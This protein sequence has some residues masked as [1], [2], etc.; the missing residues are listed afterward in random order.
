ME[1]RRNHEFETHGRITCKG[2]CVLEKRVLFSLHNSGEKTLAFTDRLFFFPRGRTLKNVSLKKKIERCDAGWDYRASFFSF[3]ERHAGLGRLR[4]RQGSQR[5]G[6]KALKK[7]QSGGE[8]PPGYT[9]IF[10]QMVYQCRGGVGIAQ[11]IARVDGFI[12]RVR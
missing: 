10:P 6:P 5:L 7:V 2:L 4:E 3:L 1:E 11:V 8:E 12:I 9:V